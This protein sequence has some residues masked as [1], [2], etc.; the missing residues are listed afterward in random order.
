M[1]K[2]AVEQLGEDCGSKAI[3]RTGHYAYSGEKD[4]PHRC[5]W[6]F[7]DILIDEN[8]LRSAYIAP[9]QDVTI[10][11]GPYRQPYAWQDTFALAL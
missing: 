5:M 8:S 4:V 10:D 2:S 11:G 7:R 3:L 1:H 6:G 9:A